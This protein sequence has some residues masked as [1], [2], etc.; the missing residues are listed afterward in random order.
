M[1]SLSL[2]IVI[3]CLKFEFANFLSLPY[4]RLLELGQSNLGLVIE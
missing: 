2:K 3:N 4:V 1:T